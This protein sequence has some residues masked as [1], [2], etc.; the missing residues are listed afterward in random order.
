MKLKGARKK[1]LYFLMVRVWSLASILVLVFFTCLPIASAK[2]EESGTVTMEEGDYVTFDLGLFKDFPDHTEV[3]LK[4][5]EINGKNIDVYL[6]VDYELSEYEGDA[7]FDPPCKEE[8]VSSLKET[9]Q[10]GQAGYDYI[11]ILDNRDN[12]RNRDAL[13]NGNATVTYSYEKEN[14]SF[15]SPELAVVGGCCGGI[16]IIAL[17]VRKWDESRKKTWLGHPDHQQ[18][19]PSYPRG[20]SIHFQPRRPPGYPSYRG[21]HPAYGPPTYAHSQSPQDSLPPQEHP[22]NRGADSMSPPPAPPPVAP[23]IDQERELE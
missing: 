19:G 2:V 16:I 7:I 6:L 1:E 10:P 23:A 20:G 8:R 21:H 5:R 14:W 9:W 13:P 3:K 17:V 18:G 12:G 15:F 11:L 22:V 4:I